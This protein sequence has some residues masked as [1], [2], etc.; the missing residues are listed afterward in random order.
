MSVTREC[1]QYHEVRH[2]D[3]MQTPVSQ[4]WHEAFTS[5]SPQNQSRN[6][7]SEISMKRAQSRTP[8]R[9]LA[10]NSLRAAT[11]ASSNASTSRSSLYT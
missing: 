5:R 11:I 2:C 8:R 4:W 7:H 9:Q 6:I 10:T 3:S 1:A